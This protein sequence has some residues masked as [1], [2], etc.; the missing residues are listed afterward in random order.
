[1]AKLKCGPGNSSGSDLGPVIS[2]AAK[3]RIETMIQS[4]ADQGAD[5]LLDGRNPQVPAGCENGYFV[6]PTV[7]G[8]VQKGMRIYDKERI[9]TMIQSG[10]D[11]GADVLLDGR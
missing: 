9:E 7:F 4:G 10:A 1:M 8:N 5:V 6:G 2:L 11:Q 3:E